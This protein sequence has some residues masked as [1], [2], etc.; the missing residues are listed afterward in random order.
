[1]SQQNLPIQMKELAVLQQ[2]GFNPSLIKLGTLSFESDKFICAKEVDQQGTS[3]IVCDVLKNMAFSKRKMSKADGV[4]MHPTQNIMAVRANNGQ[5]NIMIQVYNLDLKQK[6]KDINVNYEITFWKWL[7][8]KTI[9]LV[10]PSS[11]FILDISEMNSPPRKVFDR[12]GGIAGNN[13]FVMNLT[14]DSN[15][16]WYALSAITSSNVGG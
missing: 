3:V 13:V 14:C 7:D 4:M 15:K 2:H 10:S 8:E 11:V 9:G 5:N 16:Q 1:M 12:Q 6:L